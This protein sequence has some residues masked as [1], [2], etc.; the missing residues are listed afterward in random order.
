K[1]TGENKKGVTE[2]TIKRSKDTFEIKGSTTASEVLRNARKA[3]FN[4]KLE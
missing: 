3:G 1:G 2:H 4:F